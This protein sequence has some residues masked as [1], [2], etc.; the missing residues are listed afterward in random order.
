MTNG[1]AEVRMYDDAVREAF[2]FLIEEFSFERVSSTLRT[3]EHRIIFENETTRV[4]I[5]YEMGSAPWVELGKRTAPGERGERYDLRFLLMKRVPYEVPDISERARHNEPVRPTVQR[6]A[7]LL[8]DN[9][10]DILTGNFSIFPRLRVR[11][12][13]N[14]AR[15]SAALYGN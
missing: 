15:T 13:E 1:D 7:S 11:A 9:A 5:S 12:E 4:V 14:L 3:P 2:R 6:L 8:R 10:S